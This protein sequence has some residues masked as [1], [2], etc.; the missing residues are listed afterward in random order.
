MNRR[1][2]LRVMGLATGASLIPVGRSGF[3][4]VNPHA[5]RGSGRADADTPRLG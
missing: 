1:E 5:N 4:A 2:F 3:A